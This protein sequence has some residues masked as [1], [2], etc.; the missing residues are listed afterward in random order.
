MKLI[1]WS[2]WSAIWNLLD[3]CFSL[4]LCLFSGGNNLCQCRDGEASLG[5]IVIGIHIGTA[6]IIFC[7]LFLMFGYRRRYLPL[8]IPSVTTIYTSTR[9]VQWSTYAYVKLCKTCSHKW[10]LFAVC[11]AVKGLRTAGLYRG[12]TQHTM[13]T[14]KM[15]QTVP[16]WIQCLR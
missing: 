6:C 2:V 13:A 15:D 7:V 12:T 11:F 3:P 4:V 9:L 1:V 14:L 10:N 5:S 16:E 8:N